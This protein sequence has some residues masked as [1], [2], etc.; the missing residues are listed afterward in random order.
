MLL[1]K[2]ALGTVAYLGGLPAILENFT[3]AWGQMIAYNNEWV[4]SDN[5]IHLDRATYSD[6]AP[7]RNSLVSSFLGN[8][9]IMLDTDH[10]FEP[11]IINRLTWIAD[12][13]DIDVLS[14]I[15]LMKRHPHVP[16]LYQ[17]VGDKENPALQPMANWDKNLKVV[18]IGSAGG[19]CLFVRRRVFD[20]IT[21]ELNEQPFDHIGAYSEDHSFFFRLKKLDIPAY[22]ALHVQCH[23]L[24]IAE[25]TLD[26]LPKQG[27]IQISEPFEMR[28]YL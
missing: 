26:D 20:R 2:K 5:Y 10:Y 28:G 18:Q 22:A 24:R 1:G 19:G 21:A 9:L 14:G 15:Y 25:V 7:A 6:H 11:D 23:H 12:T 8:W 27:E 13:L 3:W 4:L 17:W 16:V